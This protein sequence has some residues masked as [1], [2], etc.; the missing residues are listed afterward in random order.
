VLRHAVHNPAEVQPWLHAELFADPLH[1]D[2]LQALADGPSPADAVATSP[3]AVADLLARLVAEEPRS[4]DPFHAVR[5]LL[6]EVAQRE[7]REL[8]LTTASVGDPAA[9]LADT[10]LLHRCSR[11][12]APEQRD[13]DTS[14]VAANRLLAWL[15]Q[16]VG[17]GG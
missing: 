16:R 7:L 8:S 4:E 12:L 9:D 13:V 10:A 14:V 11:D 3:P 5:L 1:R 15:R 2:V 17:D 6:L